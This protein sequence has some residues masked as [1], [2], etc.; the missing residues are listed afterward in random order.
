MSLTLTHTHRVIL[1]GLVVFLLVLAFF[2]YQRLS[3]QGIFADLQNDLRAI[4]PT[5]DASY[6]DL[7]GNVIDLRTYKGR[8]IIINAWAT[9]MPFSHTE[10]P[11]IDAVASRYGDEIVIIGMNRMEDR[12]FIQAFLTTLAPMPH[13]LFL[14]DPADTFYRGIDGYA[15]PETV[16]YREDGTMAQHIRGVITE[17]D[18]ISGI[19]EIL[20]D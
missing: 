17:A 8:P 16:F 11:L 9:W 2:V 15:M 7:E 20:A 3:P 5:L 12:T 10:L 19:E 6:T 13:T 14:T 1:C 18:L 4:D